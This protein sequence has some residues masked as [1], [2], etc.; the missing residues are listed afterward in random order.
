M[1]AHA[2]VQDVAALAR[3][4]ERARYKDGLPDGPRAR[5]A[6]AAGVA[7]LAAWEL[8]EANG[9]VT[10][11]APARAL[12]DE[13]GDDDAGLDDGEAGGD[14]T[15]SDG[16][17]SSGDEGPALASRFPEVS[18]AFLSARRWEV[19]AAL[20]FRRPEKMHVMGSRA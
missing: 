16:E 19:E 5:A 6:A 14:D 17:L 11:R 13:R 8:D 20:P 9:L 12:D 10:L 7:E 15:G 1:S 18:A 3:I 4:K 2:G